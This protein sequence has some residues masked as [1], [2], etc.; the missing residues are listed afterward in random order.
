VL[1][2][3][4]HLVIKKEKDNNNLIN[5]GQKPKHHKHHHRNKNKGPRPDGGQPPNQI[6]RQHDL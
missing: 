2:D 3:N 6:N 5:K 4:I 1:K